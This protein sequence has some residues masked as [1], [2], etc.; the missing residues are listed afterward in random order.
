MTTGEPAG[1]PVLRHHRDSLL[2][3]VAAALSLK[4]GEVHTL[5][6]D[7]DPRRPVLHHLVAD[8]LDALPTEARERFTGRCP[9]A[10]LLSQH[11]AA[12]DGRRSKR[13]ARKPMTLHEARKAL[14]G[15]RMTTVRI[16]EE[17][18]PAH[19]SHAPP[20]RSCA[21]MLEHFTVRSVAVGPP[22]H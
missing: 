10:V 3:A 4:G 16:R 7:K 8:F 13:A 20:C 9:E 1:P 12:V 15:S 11:L 14:K 21:P 5:A 22:A 6:G 18:D 19:G 2:P 17:G